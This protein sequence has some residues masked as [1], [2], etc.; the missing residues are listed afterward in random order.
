MGLQVPEQPVPL[1]K[2]W[3]SVKGSVQA[4]SSGLQVNVEF[5][6]FIELRNVCRSSRPPPWID[7]SLRRPVEPNV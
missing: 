2:S 1:G 6:V 5:P 7:R 3:N 4:V